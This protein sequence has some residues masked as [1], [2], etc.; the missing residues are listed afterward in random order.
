M[1]AEEAE[2]LF[3]QVL[4]EF[5]VLLD[6][7]IVNSRDAPSFT[8]G[9]VRLPSMFL[10]KPARIV[11]QILRHE[12]GHRT[13]FPGKP[14]W[15]KLTLLI[16]ARKGV[17]DTENF[18]NAVAD[19]IVD[20][21][22]LKKYGQEYYERVVDAAKGYRGKDPRFWFMLSTYQLMAEELGLKTPNFIKKAEKYSIKPDELVVPKAKK[23]L[24]ILNS[25]AS[26]EGKIEQLAELLK[27]LFHSMYKS[28]FD[29]KIKAY[30]GVPNLEKL[31]A[32]IP[33]PGLMVKN[34]GRNPVRDPKWLSRM[35]ALLVGYVSD[36][37]ICNPTQI[38]VFLSHLGVGFTYGIFFMKSDV[39]IEAARLSLYAKYVEALEKVGASGSKVEELEQWTI[40]DLPHELRVEETMRIYG[41]VLPP[42]FSLKFSTKEEP[43]GGAGSGSTIIIIDVSGSMIGSKLERAKE[44]AFSILQ[45]ARKRGDEVKLVFF[46]GSALALPHG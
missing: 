15:E 30:G 5:G 4:Q 33:A 26:L 13:V 6:F 42:V 35:I 36:P 31:G 16:A 27:D 17:T 28:S 14:D 34:D 46:N 8:W 32:L 23:A 1:K 22:H 37:R 19:L 9:V 2:K 39:M 10:K 24:K 21:E 3:T 45:E 20:Q 43:S 44:A 25:N 11:K 41:E 18:A 7:K 12:V 38:P 40:G 29:D